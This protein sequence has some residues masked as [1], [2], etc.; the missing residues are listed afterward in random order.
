MLTG[1]CPFV[2]ENRI[3]TMHAIL[4]QEP[5]LPDAGKEN[6]LL[7]SCESWEGSAKDSQEI[8]IKRSRTWPLNS[9]PSSATWSW[10]RHSS[11]PLQ[12]KLV[13]KRVT[14]AR[15]AEGIDYEKE[16]NEAQLKAVM[17]TEGPLLIVAGAG[18]GKRGPWC[19]A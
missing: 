3:D 1:Q 4:H 16:L 9:R 6:F 5:K 11:R 13:L 8:V 19:I 2:N 12:T 15:Q 14:G 10:A 7:T 17:T 18:T